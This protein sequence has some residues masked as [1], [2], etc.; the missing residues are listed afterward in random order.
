MAMTTKERRAKAL[1]TKRGSRVN[2]IKARTDRGTAIG[3]AANVARAT[4]RLVDLEPVIRA[5]H[6]E[7]KTTLNQIASELNER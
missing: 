4:K 1:G 2:L 6:S 7:G 3:N 5:I